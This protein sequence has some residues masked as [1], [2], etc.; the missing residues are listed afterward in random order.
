MY[1]EFDITKNEFFMISSFQ[2]ACNDDITCGGYSVYCKPCAEFQYQNGIVLFDSNDGVVTAKNK[3][4]FWVHL[5][6]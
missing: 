1:T 5:A 3:N 2:L 6:K 4:E